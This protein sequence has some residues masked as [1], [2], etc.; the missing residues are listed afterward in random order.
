[1]GN[2]TFEI[3]Q[4]RNEIVFEQENTVAETGISVITQNISMPKPLQKKKT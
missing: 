3:P 2:V 1:M 4:K